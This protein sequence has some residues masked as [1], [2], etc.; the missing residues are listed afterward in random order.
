MDMDEKNDNFY[1]YELE[2]E[3][4]ERFSCHLL[5][6]HGQRLNILLKR[7]KEIFIQKN[8]P[9]KLLELK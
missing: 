7:K 6:K 8:V 3:S 9:K 2:I 4:Q 5:W 1:C